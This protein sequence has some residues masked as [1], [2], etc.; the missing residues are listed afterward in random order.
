MKG[1]LLDAQTMR[2]AVRGCQWVAHVASPFVIEEPADENELIKPA[3]EGTLSVLRAC[4]EFGVK[5]VC[6]TSSVAAVAS[7]DPR[8][9]PDEFDEST[10]SDPDNNDTMTAYSKSKTFAEKAAWDFMKEAE[11]EGSDLQ[12]SV[13]NP[14]FVIGPTLVGG[15]FASGKILSKIMTGEIPKFPKISFGVVDVRNVAEAHVRA[16]QRD[17]A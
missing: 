6:V 16:L 4:K 9:E 1:D 13:I 8:T 15:T 17:E 11:K 2:D 10:W 14:V 5:R 3:V 7:P 12:M